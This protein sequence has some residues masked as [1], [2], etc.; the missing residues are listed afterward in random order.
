[1]LR[2]L[3][4]VVPMI[5]VLAARADAQA[6]LQGHVFAEQARR[7]V[8]N[9]EVSIPRLGLRA[10]SD[11]LGRY[12]L[13]AVPRGEHVVVTRA[14]GFRPDSSVIAFDGDEAIVSD[15]VLGIAVNELPTVPVR[16][17]GQPVARG[18]MA[19]FEERKALG[20]GTFIDRGVLEKDENRNLAEILA[21][22]APGIS[23]YRGTGSKAWAAS[24]RTGGSSAKCAFCKV[25]RNEMLDQFDIA[26]G[27]PLACYLDVYLDG[28]QVYSASARQTPLFNLNSMQASEIEAI[29]VYSSA[30]RIPAQYNRT[31][32]GCG[33]ML[34]WTRD[35]R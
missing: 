30:A 28:T 27:A 25:T 20:V 23:V 15:V 12:R 19:A 1:M 21:S 33:V 14:V 17:T 6:E 26:A 4:A 16:A 9:A 13:Q 31:S 18:K 11:S 35:K 22:N 32:G 3:I 7:P 29:E 10:V 24:G 8:K 2:T 34:I 5:A